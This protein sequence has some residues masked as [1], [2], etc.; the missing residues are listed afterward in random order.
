MHLRLNPVHRK[1]HE[2]HAE[3]RV[4]T[5]NGLHE[6]HVPFLDEIGLGE[7]I[8]GIGPGHMHHEAQVG[9]NKATRGLEIPFV[10]QGPA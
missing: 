3:V 9:Q 1:G 6:A 7:A 10:A 8:A 4:E 2:A 5:L